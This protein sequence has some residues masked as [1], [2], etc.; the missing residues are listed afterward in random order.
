[1][2]LHNFLA[3]WS[4]WFW[5]LAI[6]H[7]WQATLFALLVWAAMVLLR[8]ASPR[9]RHAARVLALAKFLLPAAGLVVAIDKFGLRSQRVETLASDFS[10]GAL[11][12]IETSESVAEVNAQ[13][14]HVETYCALTLV[15]AA[16]AI[17]VFAYW[18][19]RRWQLSKTLRAESAE[20]T[21]RFAE[22]FAELQRRLGF[23]RPVPLIVSARIAEPG[24]WGIWRPK[25]VLPPS[26]DERLGDEELTAVLMHEL[27]HVRQRDNLL[28]T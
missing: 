18:Q 14:S 22:I 2:S 17:A 15:W 19:A 7:L 12:L 21:G 10:A 5:P 23:T 3:E 8:Q 6:N 20:V 1:M 13:A 27:I 4:Q 9:M 16:G 24:V 25:I 28:S 11:I 26:L